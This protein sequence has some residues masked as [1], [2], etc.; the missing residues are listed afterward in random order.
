MSNYR[1]LFKQFFE[2]EKAAGL[3]LLVCTVISLTLANSIWGDGYIALLHQ[4]INLSF[5]DV[6]LNYSIEHWINDGLMAIFFLMVGLEVKRELYVGE[7]SHLSKAILPLAGAFGGMIVPAGIHFLFN[8]NTE[9]QP[10]FAIPMAT[11]I[12]F[13]LGMLSLAGKKAPT[14]LKVFLS[15]L[16]IIDDIGAIIVIALFY[17]ETVYFTYLLVAMVILIALLVANRFKVN[18]LLFYL[19]PGVVLW[20]CLLKS[21]VHATLAGVLLALVI[22][23]HKSD[24]NNTSFRLQ[25]LLHKPVAFFI[26]PVFALANTAIVIPGD[27]L[28]ALSSSNSLG[29]ML[30]LFV[31]KA[32][33]IFVIPYLLV[34]GRVAKMPLRMHWRNLLGV[35]CLGGIGFTMSMFI[36]NLAFD[37]A[38]LIV[39]SKMSILLASAVSSIVGLA[40]IVTSRSR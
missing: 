4:K 5:G 40:I 30:G 28:S 13:A 25:H 19:V 29:I 12:A 36:T 26:V 10:G 33:G 1:H 35:A 6:S 32:V 22:P 7:I 39:G 38:A 17:T 11:D 9:A 3:L 2:S 8:Y 27:A 24:E 34:L 20:Y 37:D 21:G 14:S 23:F 18:N 16:A 31:G 15:A